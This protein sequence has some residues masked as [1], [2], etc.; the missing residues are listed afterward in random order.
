MAGRQGG[1]DIQVS[2]DVLLWTCPPAR[3]ALS[4]NLETFGKVDFPPKSWNFFE[5]DYF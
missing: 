5:K 3:V 1:G 4:V 2:A